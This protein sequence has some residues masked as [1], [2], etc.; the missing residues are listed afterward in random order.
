MALVAAFKASG[1]TVKSTLGDDSRCQFVVKSEWDDAVQAEGRA[2]P[3]A[4]QHKRH[5]ERLTVTALLRESPRLR[6]CRQDGWRN[7][8]RSANK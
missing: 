2:R 5:G 8:N 7:K 1:E 6:P 4:V 3:V